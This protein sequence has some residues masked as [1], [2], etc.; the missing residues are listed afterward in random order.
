MPEHGNKWG[1]GHSGAGISVGRNG[2]VVLEH[3][4]NNMPPALVW[5]A[6][7]PLTGDNHIAVVYNKGVPALYING[8]HVKDGMATG[9]KVHPSP[10]ST[11]SFNGEA[12]GFQTFAEAIPAERVFAVSNEKPESNQ[13][14]Q[15]EVISEA[16]GALTLLAP[17]PGRYVATLSDG[18]EKEWQVDS[19]PRVAT[20]KDGPWRVEFEQ[21]EDMKCAV[22]W[23]DLRDWKDADDPLI[24]YY[25]G[26]AVYRRD[27]IWSNS[28]EGVQ[29]LLDLGKV[30]E[31]ALVRLNGERL[32]ILWHPPFRVDIT[33]AL[34]NGKNTIEIR[35]ANKWFNRFIGD[36]QYPDDTG[37]AENGRVATWP[38]WVLENRE[39][40]QKERISFTSN[41]MAGKDA[42]LQ[43]S[44][45]LGD[46]LL[47]SRRIIQ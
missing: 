41:R 1:D 23:N 22:E 3:W 47:I 20:L 38:E 43:S 12:I 36:A 29:V 2:V 46:V 45:L 7:Q 40:P 24:K 31:I 5:E 44:G 4:S 30:K 33:E 26:T 35:V 13:S 17:R 19:V 6:K 18:T 34:V 21:R 32:G 15:A 37:A 27:F 10:L 39:R 28:T 8:K 11:A 9:Q 42:P 16:D 25:S 14:A